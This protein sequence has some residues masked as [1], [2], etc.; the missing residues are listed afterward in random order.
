MT[1]ST[2]AARGSTSR[3]KLAYIMSRFPKLTETFILREM[4]AV[5]ELGARVEV[6]PLLRE[7]ADGG[8]PEGEPYLARARYLPF[9]N[10]AII[11]SQLYFLA[12]R[13]RLYLSTLLLALRSTWGSRNFFLG[14]LGIYPKAAHM[15]RLMAREGVDHVHCHFASHPA[16][17]GFVIQRL[18]DIPFSFTAH[19]SDLHVERR[20]LCRKVEEA[21]FVVA[22][23]EY[24]RE[25]IV[26]E[27]G[28]DA[29]Q[30]IVVIHCGVDTARLRRQ[31]APP[32]GGFHIVQIG[33]LHEVKG[34]R[35]LLDACAILARHGV[36]F[37][38]TFVG[39]GDDRPML[40]QRARDLGVDGRVQFVGV[41][42]SAE[43]A[44]LLEQTHVLVAPSVP[45]RDG[46]REGIP[47]VLME[48]MSME[49][50]VVASRLSGIP[51]LVEDGTSGLLVEPGDSG[52]LAQALVA[53]HDDIDR[54]RQLAA[55]GRHV[56]EQ[57]FDIRRSAA[58]LLSNIIG[59][60]AASGPIL[61]DRRD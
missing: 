35:Y 20:M 40:E 8:Q 19:G 59:P 47:V 23:S 60:E 56:A 49:V 29:R 32:A 11:R 51:E 7:P 58:E 9:V 55:S 14:A 33:T 38:C 26:R 44:S 37:T 39:A 25:V 18:A 52:G 27:C 17:A 12:H 54:R 21:T 6:F 30:K 43:I 36:E 50:A 61:A 13:P 1:S 46:K 22:I 42:S 4:I 34:Q 5:E 24:N 45:A 48:A 57:R 10:A 53:L 16:L 31:A 41:L 28:E 2:T 15:A 3:L